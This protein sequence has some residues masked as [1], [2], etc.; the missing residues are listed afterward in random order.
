MQ[1]KMALL[2]PIHSTNH[3]QILARRLK[4]RQ[5]HLNYINGFIK[6]L[7]EISHLQRI[8][9]SLSGKRNVASVQRKRENDS[10][11]NEYKDTRIRWFGTDCLRYLFYHVF[12]LLVVINPSGYEEGAVLLSV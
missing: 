2:R 1:L 4:S 5:M 10:S 3:R 11:W 7:M 9:R 12:S 8:S 6:L